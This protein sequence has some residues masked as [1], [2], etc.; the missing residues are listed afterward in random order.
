[1]V[2]RLQPWKGQH[3]LVQAVAEL[4][5]AGVD[6]S[7]LVVGGEA[8]GESAGFERALH[9]QVRN[10]CLEGCV[11]FTGHVE[12]PTPYLHAGDVCVNASDGE[13]FGIVLLEAMAA[14]LPVVAVDRAGPREIVQP[15]TTGV[16][17][18]QATVW[19]LRSALAQ[20]AGDLAGAKRMGAAA[21]ALVAERFSVD[22]MAENFATAL[23]AL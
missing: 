5:D 15:G 21:R 19:E 22:H 20:L 11:H 16:L 3:L 23:R 2:G 1:M 7:A 12:D 13:P 6:A 10:L 14:G 17:I 8:F 4:R 9:E 18:E